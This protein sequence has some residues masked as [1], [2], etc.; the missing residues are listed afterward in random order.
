MAHWR[1][2]DSLEVGPEV[3]Q[4]I[5]YLGSVGRPDGDIADEYQ[6]DIS[7]GKLSLRGR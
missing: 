6:Q 1:P 4:K 2:D 5:R 3:E 7:P